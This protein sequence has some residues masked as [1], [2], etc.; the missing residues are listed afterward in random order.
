MPSPV[1][2]LGLACSEV[3]QAWDWPVVG[4]AYGAQD[5]PVETSGSS[6][7]R[8]KNWLD[9]L[10][11]VVAKNKASNLYIMDL[12]SIVLFVPLSYKRGCSQV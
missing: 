10:G 4:L 11:G 2:G 1:L 9:Q 8:E 12:K 6:L 7:H 5:W 3:K